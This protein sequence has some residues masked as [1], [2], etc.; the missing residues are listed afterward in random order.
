MAS[1]KVLPLPKVSERAPGWILL[2]PSS[3]L[4]ISERDLT[5]GRFLTGREARDDFLPCPFFEDDIPPTFVVLPM[6]LGRSPET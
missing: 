2:L 6:G 3:S 1:A 4:S 5:R